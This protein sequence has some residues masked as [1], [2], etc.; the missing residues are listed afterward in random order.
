MDGSSW[1]LNGMWLMAVLWR[2]V[3]GIFGGWCD[4]PRISFEARRAQTQACHC[5]KYF[6]FCYKAS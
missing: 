1:A 6:V 5:P 3:R 2:L 4:F